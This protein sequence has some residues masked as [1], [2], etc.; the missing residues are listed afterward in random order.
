MKTIIRTKTTKRVKPQPGS[1]EE[2]ELIINLPDVNISEDEIMEE[3]KKVRY[4]AKK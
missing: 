2:L 3:V 4:A 1:F